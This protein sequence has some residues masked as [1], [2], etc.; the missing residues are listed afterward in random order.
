M[1]CT[2]MCKYHVCA[3]AQINT[4]AFYP[5]S[6][7]LSLSTQLLTVQRHLEVYRKL[8]SFTER[9]AVPCGWTG[10]PPG[11]AFLGGTALTPHTTQVVSHYLLLCPQL[12]PLP[13]LLFL[14]G[15]GEDKAMTTIK[16]INSVDIWASFMPGS[17]L[18]SK[19]WALNKIDTFSALMSLQS[20]SLR[21][22]LL[23]YSNFY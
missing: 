18:G 2:W 23:N 17:I 15:R 13:G 7:H 12:W 5:S 9:K 20:S 6:F 4:S 8:L 11:T 16:F 14:P 3:C 21:Y 19:D 1:L 22:D 10:R